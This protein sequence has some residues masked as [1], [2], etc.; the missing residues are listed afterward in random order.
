MDIAEWLQD[1]GLERYAPAFRDNKID[2]RVLP[3]LT[4]DDLKDLGVP[5]V[6][7]R[8]RLL[9]AIAALGAAASAAAAAKSPAPDGLAQGPRTPP[10]PKHLADKI[11]QARPALEG[12]RKHITVL[13]ADVKGSMTLAERLDPEQW[14]RVVEDFFQVVADGVHR[15]EGTVNQFTGDGVM[16]L[17]GAPIAHEDHA[18]RACL[19]AL[20]IRDAVRAFAESVRV[21]HA[22]QFDSQ[23][24]AVEIERQLDYIPG[25]GHDGGASPVVVV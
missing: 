1:L 7:H 15:F 16:A 9:D 21:R 19:A 18:Q 14:F 5:L 4:A 24:I 20:Y 17:F 25:K 3:G 23:T 22:V 12:E 2:E 8:R 10:P 6:G 13:F 11:R